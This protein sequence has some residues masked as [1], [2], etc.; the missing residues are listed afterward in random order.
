MKN[1]IRRFIVCG[2]MGIAAV[3]AGNACG[4]LEKPLVIVQPDADGNYPSR[5]AVVKGDTPLKEGVFSGGDRYFDL[6]SYGECEFLD[7]SKELDIE[8]VAAPNFP[9][10]FTVEYSGNTSVVNFNTEYDRNY[11]GTVSLPAGIAATWADIELQSLSNSGARRNLC[12][13][14]KRF[15]EDGFIDVLYKPFND[16]APL[17]A[18]VNHTSASIAITPDDKICFV[19]FIS[20]DDLSDSQS[21]HAPSTGPVNASRL[22]AAVDFSNVYRIKLGG[23]RSYKIISGRTSGL[24]DETQTEIKHFGQT[25]CGKINGLNAL[26]TTAE[27]K[28]AYSLDGKNWKNLAVEFDAA[29]NS[30]SLGGVA[31]GAGYWLI[32]TEGGVFA[33]EDGNNCCSKISTSDNESGKVSAL[34][35]A[36]NTFVAFIG[37]KAYSLV[38]EDGPFS[39]LILSSMGTVGTSDIT[40]VGY[41]N[42]RWICGASDGT[43]FRYDGGPDNE[44]AHVW[45]KIGKDG[46][47]S[48]LGNGSWHGGTYNG[49]LYVIDTETGNISRSGDRGVTWTSYLNGEKPFNSNSVTVFNG[50]LYSVSEDGKTYRFFQPASL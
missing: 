50:D 1:N 5:S 38:L 4:T 22:A 12:L 34:A 19:P 48:S 17:A 32:G 18:E 44:G 27:E 14:I 9:N 7:Y 13:G 11:M 41:N 28:L 33:L 42:E 26:V 47:D 43:M 2:A 3:F 30:F 29:G 23:F 46:E 36:D 25:G 45:T 40:I 20:S 35:F 31:Y 24:L 10:L 21:S 8:T 15:G 6:A 39:P 37:N 16:D 49:N